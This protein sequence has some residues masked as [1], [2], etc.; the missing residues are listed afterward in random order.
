MIKRHGI[1]EAVE[2]ALKTPTVTQGHT[3]LA[4]MGLEEYAFEAGILRQPSV[5]SDEGVE[6]SRQRLRD[7]AK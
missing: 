2:R 1:I 5:F 3:K 6:I 7:W 4:E